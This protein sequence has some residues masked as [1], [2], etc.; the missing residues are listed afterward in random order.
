MVRRRHFASVGL[1]ALL[2]GC[3]NPR[4]EAVTTST[5]VLIGTW[6]LNSSGYKDGVL[7]QKGEIRTSC[8][9]YKADGTYE[10]N[11]QYVG[12]RLNYILTEFGTWTYNGSFLTMKPT[13]NNRKM[14]TGTL[15]EHPV[16]PN[17]TFQLEIH[18]LTA[19]KM[20]R[21]A[22]KNQYEFLKSKRP[23][24]YSAADLKPEPKPNV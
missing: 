23:K 3:Q 22:G 12:G 5:D 17:H 10:T 8:T 18:E 14:I 16:L 21:S 19:T 15:N 24:I 7:Q 1:I 11:K 2:A 20:R 4:V 6:T 13:K 9:E